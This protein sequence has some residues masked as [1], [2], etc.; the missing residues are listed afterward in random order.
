[1]RSIDRI[2]GTMK[3]SWQC[4]FRR[5][6]ADTAR[7]APAPAG[8]SD[9]DAA[10]ADSLR[11]IHL[12]SICGSLLVVAIVAVTAVFAVSMRNQAITDTERELSNVGLILAEQ[13]AQSFRAL[14]LVQDSIVEHMRASKVETERDLDDAMA[15]QNIHHMLADKISGLPQIDAVTIINEHGRLINFSR[16]WPIPAVNVADRD[17]FEA[18]RNDGDRTVFLSEPVQNR[19]TGTWTIY[20]AR[21]ITSSDKRF[22]G[23]VLG[24]MRLRYFEQQFASIAF[25][26]KQGSIA[27]FRRDG[28]L[29]TRHPQQADTVGRIYARVAAQ[30]DR[31]ANIMRVISDI[32]GESRLVAARSVRGFPAVV[33]VSTRTSAATVQ[34]ERDAIRLAGAGCALALAV[35]LLVFI[36][37]RRTGAERDRVQRELLRQQQKLDVAI[38]NMTQ[39]LVMFDAE[40]RLALGNERHADMY[41]LSGE[42]V[43]PGS[44]LCAIVEACK[45]A[46][47]F[48]GDVDRYC[49]DVMASLKKGGAAVTNELPDG[50]MIHV[51]N[52]PLPEGGWVATHE[53]VTETRRAEAE[54]DRNRDLL[55]KVI[56]NV[57]VM[58]IVKN[59]TDL[60]Y[61]LLNKASEDQLGLGDGRGIGRSA[62]DLFDEAA[63][64]RVEH[65]DRHCLASGQIL[66]VDD[67]Q[68]KLPLAG[69]RIHK[70][71]RV[72]IIGDNGKPQYLLTVAED[73][74][75]RKAVESQLQQAMKMEAVG[76]L[77]GGVA[78]DFNNLLMV[79]I[80]NLDLLAE[81]VV[82][83]EQ[84]RDKVDI[85][86]RSALAGAEL[87][88]QMLAFARRQ[89]LNPKRIIVPDL[90]KATARLLGR[91][92]GDDV[93]LDLRIAD[94]LWAIRVDE[95]Q[96]QSSIVNIAINA[97]DAMPGG[98]RLVIEAENS[99]VDVDR[100]AT[101][102]RIT[103]GEYVVI[104]LSDS[105]VGMPP[106]DIARVFEP[107]FTT[108]A[109]GKGSGLGL[110]MVYGF[111]KQSGGHVGIY[112][113]VGR[114]TTLR[115]YLP[116]D[117]ADA[118]QRLEPEIK[119]LPLG[120][121]ETILAVDDNKDVLTTVARQL[122]D[123]GYSVVTA[124]SAFSALRLLEGG[125]AADLLFSDMVMPGGLSG[126][127]LADEAHRMFP[128]LKILLT[129][130]YSDAFLA[131]DAE[132]HSTYGLLTKP[133]RKHDLA[134]AVRR[135]LDEP[136]SIAAE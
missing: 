14:E 108:K 107:F 33:T 100:A 119:Q 126:K 99:L 76:N 69:A 53:D 77:T 55:D 78:H 40:G 28:M 46:G 49:S 18:L 66:V 122:T 19:G 58:I 103:A 96:L 31:P 22:L 15:G 23:L 98:G 82:D 124:G 42:A 116:R 24:A 10:N 101:R 134:W 50:R 114:G 95:S 37:A 75:D 73:L 11:Q 62:R 90:I 59:A 88:R 2:D 131:H 67:H 25:S 92:L 26:E 102:D 60:T 54:R 4:W 93:T 21:K 111:T 87:T 38:N 113:E 105:G 130:G 83:N 27:L 63:A 118:A 106:E 35:G 85:V 97:R 135:I 41:R 57:P 91:T 45:S 115:L 3:R 110:S 123:L 8:V 29:L 9:T 125:L 129:S 44:D 84:A 5:K 65:D 127:D 72:P 64:E 43:M 117:T 47:T 34:A 20:L 80:G 16:Y 133:Y 36:V 1:M 12:L 136:S 94:D 51:I 112:S 56:E 70:T 104:S 39:G 71:T 13:T 128:D 61:A 81:D 132:L 89:P 7:D 6:H 79:M 30:I 32:D 120:G 121:G 17:Y 86:L 74:T 68:I 48:V 52:R 109:H